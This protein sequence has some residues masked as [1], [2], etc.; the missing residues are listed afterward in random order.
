M[1]CRVREIVDKIMAYPYPLRFA[2][3]HKLRSKQRGFTRQ[4]YYNCVVRAAAEA[5]ALGHEGLTV[6]EFGVAS[7]QG[8][9]ELER[10]C[11]YVEKTAPVRFD[12]VGFDTGMGLPPP[13][14]YRDTPWKWQEGWYDMDVGKLKRSLARAK[15]VLGPV[16]ETVPRFLAEGLSSPMGAIMFDLD[17]FSSTT[18]AFGIF[19]QSRAEDRLPRIFCYFDD[20]GSIEDVGV[21]RAIADFNAA[22]EAKKVRQRMYWRDLRD[23]YALPWKIYEFHDFR[24][25]DYMRPVRKQKQT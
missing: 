2:L 15:L 9:L 16:A 7:G 5:A 19:S 21:P 4:H 20:L 22:H 11:S 8:L 6:V 17:Y 1:R 24:H 14:D 25:P 12:V 18:D 10:I 13:T 3:W 23:P